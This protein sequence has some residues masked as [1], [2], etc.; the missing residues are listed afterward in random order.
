MRTHFLLADDRR[1]RLYHAVLEESHADPEYLVM[2]AL[3]ALIA[4]F[5]LLQNSTAVIIGAM[6][7]S[8]LMNPI[9]AAALALILGD[10]NLGRKSAA[11]LGLSIGGAILIT[12]VVAW[13]SPL[14]A[15]T[16]EILARTNP[17]LLDLFIALLSGLAGTLALRSGSTSMTIIP[18]VAIAVAVIPPLAVVGYGLSTRQWPAA[19]GAFL[20]FMSNLVAIVLSAA[21]VFRLF[22]FRPHEEAEKGHLKLRYRLAISFIVLTTLS[23]PLLQTLHRAASQIGLRA[24]I[25]EALN[26]KFK[27]EASSVTDISFSRSH[28]K[29]LVYATLRTTRYFEAPDIETAEDSLKKQLGPNTKLQIEQILVAHGGLTAQQVARTG[30]VIS[31]GVVRPVPGTEEAPFDFKSSQ[32]KLLAQLQRQVDE[33]LAGTPIRRAGSVDVQLGVN[34]PLVFKLRLSCPEPLE[35]QT[36]KLLASQLASKISSPVEVHGEVEL[37][38]PGY[39]LLLE[40]AGLHKGLSV[41]DRQGIAKL[42]SIARNR[43]D[44]QLRITVT[45]EMGAAGDTQTPV[46]W[47]HIR[48]LLGRSGLKDS[49]WAMLRAQNH[50]AAASSTP[51]SAE[52]VKAAPQGSETQARPPHTAF[53]CEF[54][55]YQQL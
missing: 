47:N 1:D 13:L 5:G 3:S 50:Q 42:V 44:V 54:K 35:S 4:L 30:N 34:Q 28:D 24:T 22:G 48:V 37:Q 53:R 32:E 8:P 18:G 17:N 19:G 7:I 6:L 10:G 46:V 45:W 40:S 9:L 26:Q 38:G 33:V 23:V 36:V 49:Q 12:W 55:L 14:K 20:L 52:E 27:T 2:L 51:R 31:G 16:P 41:K 39:Q 29:L 15:P 25:S 43:P 21:L 11:V